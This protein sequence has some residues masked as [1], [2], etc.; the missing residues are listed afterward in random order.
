MSA[1]AAALL[2]SLDE[3]ALQ[4]L[5]ER[6]A[7]HLPPTEP[8]ARPDEWLDTKG[9]AAYLGLTTSALYKLTSAQLIPFEQEA[10]G[11][12]CY[13]KRSELD[14]WREGGGS[15]GIACWKLGESLRFH[16]ASKGANR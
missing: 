1:L 16:S 10:P 9:A 13:F 2:D 4:A 6:L 14:A 12:K 15:R 3:S 7:P 5:A 11:C 8:E